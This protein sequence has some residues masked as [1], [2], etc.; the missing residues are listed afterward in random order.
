[1]VSVMIF[2]L[3]YVIWA[4]QQWFHPIT[5]SATS[6]E[7]CNP[8]CQGWSSNFICQLVCEGIYEYSLCN[9]IDHLGFRTSLTKTHFLSSNANDWHNGVLRLTRYCLPTWLHFRHNINCHGLWSHKS[10]TIDDLELVENEILLAI[11]LY[12]KILDA[13]SI[14]H[15]K[16]PPPLQNSCSI[17]VFY[18]LSTSGIFMCV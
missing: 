9:Y 11:Q 4:E 3:Q 16:F 13:M 7:F 6:A 17:E 12:E 15:L 18:S 2:L 8:C 5:T 1:M 14:W 10:K